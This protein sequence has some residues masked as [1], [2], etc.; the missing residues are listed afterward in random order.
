MNK[1]VILSAIITF[2][3]FLFAFQ[4][5]NAVSAKA[6]MWAT[7]VPLALLIGLAFIL[8]LLSVL[9]ISIPKN[10]ARRQAL[11]DANGKVV[12]LENMLQEQMLKNKELQVDATQQAEATIPQTPMEETEEETM[13]TNP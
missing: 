3:V 7:E 8:G 13:P 4:N 12:L 9:L 1:S 10:L 5:M 2:L 11:K 6:I